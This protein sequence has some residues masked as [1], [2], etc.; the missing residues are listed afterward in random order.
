MWRLENGAQNTRKCP[1]PPPA[2]PTV[3][4]S[5]QSWGGGGGGRGRGGRGAGETGS[6]WERRVGG[7]YWLRW[8]QHWFPGLKRP[9]PTGY[10]YSHRAAEGAA[11]LLCGRYP[12]KRGAIFCPLHH[13]DA[14]RAACTLSCGSDTGTWGGG[15]GVNI[16]LVESPARNVLF[17]WFFKSGA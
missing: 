15:G 2:R 16:Q 7:V 1:P 6:K 10:I 8:Q 5:S 14:E 9:P 3:P 12:F 17:V 13:G 4:V 11:V